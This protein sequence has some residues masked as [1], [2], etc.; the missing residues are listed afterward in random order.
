MLKLHAITYAPQYYTFRQLAPECHCVL[1]CV[2]NEDEE[3]EED[4][5]DL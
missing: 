2:H 3:E 5:D 4:P 1:F